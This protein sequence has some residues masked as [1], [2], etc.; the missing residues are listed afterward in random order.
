MPALQSAHP[1]VLLIYG[2]EMDIADPVRLPG[3]HAAREET[4]YGLALFPQWVDLEAMRPGRD[5]AAS[6]PQGQAPAEQTWHPGVCFDPSSP[7]FAQ[8]GE[9]AR[10]ASAE[11]GE[12]ALSNLVKALT[13][14][15]VAHLDSSGAHP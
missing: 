4:S 2:T 10:T 1:Q 11:R 14:T 12:T 6:W 8:M 3:D 9:N 7:H 15:I 13:Q 5:C